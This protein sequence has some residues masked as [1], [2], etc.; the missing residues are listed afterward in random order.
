MGRPPRIKR[1]PATEIKKREKRKNVVERKMK[2]EQSWKSKIK[3]LVATQ[4]K[5]L[6]V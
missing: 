3:K 5:K 2:Q 4:T 1:G 6:N